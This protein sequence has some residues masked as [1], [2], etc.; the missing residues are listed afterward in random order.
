[1]RGNRI[2]KGLDVQEL[3]RLWAKNLSQQEIC[4]RLGIR[5]GSFWEIRRRLKLPRR[6][7][8][9]QP[10]KREIAADYEPTPDE[11]KERAAEIRLRW[12]PAEEA[13]RRSYRAVEVTKFRFS[14]RDFALT[15]LDS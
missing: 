8:D 9:R 3:F 12:S 13:R 6:E 11:I 7:R 5:R 4:D 10:V 1:M 2:G 15:A 14:Q